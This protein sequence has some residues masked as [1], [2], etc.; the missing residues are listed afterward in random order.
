MTMN[1]INVHIYDVHY[2]HTFLL[3]RFGLQPINLG[4]Q[5]EEDRYITF[6]DRY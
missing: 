6:Q 4:T 1:I 5:V 2:S 3:L